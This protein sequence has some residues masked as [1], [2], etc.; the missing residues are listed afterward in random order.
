MKRWHLWAELQDL[1]G[2]L[3]CGMV[4]HYAKQWEYKYPGH[5]SKLG[6]SVSELMQKLIVCRGCGRHW[7]ET[8]GDFV[9]LTHPHGDAARTPKQ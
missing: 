7:Q 2:N 1:P 6:P 3:W 5:I 8:N 4:H 9:A